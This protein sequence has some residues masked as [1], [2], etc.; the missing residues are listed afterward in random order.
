MYSLV[1]ADDETNQRE[2]LC[3]FVDWNSLG[4][5]VSAAFADGAELIEYISKNPVDVILTDIRMM[6]V[7]GL[8]VAA[9]IH[10]HSL[11]IAVVLISGHKDFEFA[12]KAIEL[13]VKRYIV[14]PVQLDEIMRIFSGL[15]KELAEK[16]PDERIS[17]PVTVTTASQYDLI[18]EKSKIYMQRRFAEE[19]SLNEVAEHVFLNPV[20]FSRFFKQRTGKNFIDY[21]TQLRMA[22]AIELLRTGKFKIY[23]ISAQVGYKDTKYFTHVFKESTGYSPKEY[24]RKLA[25]TPDEYP[26]DGA[27]GHNG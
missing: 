17:A 16:K 9:Y 3:E 1:I 14:K 24:V 4:F 5:H 8:E 13:N 20:Y 19:L 25:G 18:I 23:E 11:D 15:H 12:Q 27:G 7:S 2:G 21:L 22:K 6:D 10:E 26:T